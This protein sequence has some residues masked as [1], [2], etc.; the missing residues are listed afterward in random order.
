MMGSS[1]CHPERNPANTGWSRRISSAVH[2]SVWGKRI[3]FALFQTGTLRESSRKK[4]VGFVTSV[5]T[6]WMKRGFPSKNNEL[7]CEVLLETY[8]SEIYSDLEERAI[9]LQVSNG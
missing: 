2:W 5:Y 1:C 6:H 3:V 9:A 4:G 7:T 8:R